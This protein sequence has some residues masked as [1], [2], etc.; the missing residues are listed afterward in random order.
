MARLVV[1]RNVII[2]RSV[3]RA[4]AQSVGNGADDEHPELCGKGKSQKRRRR[5][6]HAYHGYDARAYL[7]REKVGKKAGYYRA[8]R[9]HHGY[10]A[11]AVH[12][13]AHLF[14]HDGPARTEKRIGKSKTYKRD[15]DKRKQQRVHT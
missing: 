14:V 12:G 4:R 1:Q 2:Q 6:K 7:S 3:Y 10:N 5:E 9:H 13:N 15:I 11:H 8:P